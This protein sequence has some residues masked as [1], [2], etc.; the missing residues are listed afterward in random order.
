MSNNEFKRSYIEDNFMEPIQSQLNDIESHLKLI[1]FQ[2]HLMDDN[3][4]LEKVK[5]NTLAR[6]SELEGKLAYWMN[7]CDKFA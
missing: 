5:E 1:D 3:E 4:D 7:L 2:A 6:K